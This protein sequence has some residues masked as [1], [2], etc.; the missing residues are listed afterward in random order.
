MDS[1]PLLVLDYITHSYEMRCLLKMVSKFF[2]DHV[3]MPVLSI[4]PSPRTIVIPSGCEASKVARDL[5]WFETRDLVIVEV[6]SL[7]FYPLLFSFQRVNHISPFPQD[8]LGWLSAQ[9]ASGTTYPTKELRLPNFRWLFTEQ[10]AS[11]LL[12][13]TFPDLR[14]LELFGEVFDDNNEWVP[15]HLLGLKARDG[16]DTPLMWTFNVERIFSHL[17]LVW[18]S[19]I[20]A[21]SGLGQA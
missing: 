2:R 9:V 15:D 18:E 16:D 20:V 4:V 14:K 21:S 5:A 13:V 6:A 3:R 10:S 11:R 19:P 17:E 8:I 1:L 12:L 7:D